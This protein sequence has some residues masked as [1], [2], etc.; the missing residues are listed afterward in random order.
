MPQHPSNPPTAHAQ[1]GGGPAGSPP[2]AEPQQRADRSGSRSGVTPTGWLLRGLVLCAVS[3]VSGLLWL[4]IKPDT[5]GTDAPQAGGN[6]S[7]KGLYRFDQHSREEM[8][9]CRQFSTDEIADYFSEHPCEHLTRALYTTTLP[10]GERVLTSVVTARMPNAPSAKELEKLT[11]RSGT[12]NIEDLV[13]AGRPV[14]DNFPDLNGDLGYA[15]QQQGRLVVIGESA[16]FA[17]PNRD[18]ARLK[19]VT[20]DA[21]RLGWPQDKAP[22]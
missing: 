14:P 10:G 9:G 5:S 6:S 3:V 17:N 13:S 20:T 7:Q 19:K 18:D 8:P 1:A 22:E 11:T 15:S 21:L 16:Y 4:L 2:P 12:G